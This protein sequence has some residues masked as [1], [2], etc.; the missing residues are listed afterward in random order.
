MI[1]RNTWILLGIFVILLVGA[2]LFQRDNQDEEAQTTPTEGV[3]LLFEIGER[4]ITAIRIADNQDNA[5]AV[6]LNSDGSWEL[7][8]PEGE[9][10]DEARIASAVSQAEQL[11]VLS[12]VESE[13]DLGTIGLDP[14]QYT[15]EVTYSDGSEETAYFGDETPTGSGYYAYMQDNEQL[16]V[17]N[18]FS[19]DSLLDLLNDPPIAAPTTPAPE[20]VV[21]PTASP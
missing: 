18:K 7:V 12:P 4:T 13:L 1:R 9:P 19:V 8:V 6:M 3:S 20:S 10:G 17:V 16:Q 2:W 14:A 21:T 11:R 5:V 15:I